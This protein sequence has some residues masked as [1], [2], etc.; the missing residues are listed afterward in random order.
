MSGYQ[1]GDRV[2]LTGKRWSGEMAEQVVTIVSVA[3]DQLGRH[4]GEFAWE[5]ENPALAGEWNVIKGNKF[6][7]GTVVERG[8]K[9]YLHKAA[10]ASLENLV[11]E[12]DQWEMMGD[13]EP[14]ISVA[15]LKELLS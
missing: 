12:Y 6:W 1:P 9:P 14:G 11:N 5:S 10:R 3:S 8:G 13:G 7:G 2:A 4:Y 15:K